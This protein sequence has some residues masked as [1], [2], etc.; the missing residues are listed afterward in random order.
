MYV[1]V[2]CYVMLCYV[3][4]WFGMYDLVND[5]LWYGWMKTTN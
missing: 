4:M 5:I 3:M 2:M 1:Y